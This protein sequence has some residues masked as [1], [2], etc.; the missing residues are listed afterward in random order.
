MSNWIQSVHKKN[1]RV[2]SLQPS[3]EIRVRS[4]VSR[5]KINN[6]SCGCIQKRPDQTS[7]L[8]RVECILEFKA[9]FFS[10][11]QLFT[12]SYIFRIVT[13]FNLMWTVMIDLIYSFV[14]PVPVFSFVFLFLYE[15]YSMIHRAWH[16][17]LS[18]WLN[19][20]VKNE[21]TLTCG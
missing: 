5:D 21:P 12:I 6:Q 14:P 7:T 15:S 13:F 19:H 9:T 4:R 1:E 8:L 10:K 3:V 17:H 20:V 18:P 16:N 11:L 2:L